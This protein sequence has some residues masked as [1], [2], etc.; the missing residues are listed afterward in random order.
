M[1]RWAHNVAWEG[2]DGA[3]LAGAQLWIIEIKRIVRA[4]KNRDERAILIAV[5]GLPENGRLQQARKRFRH[6]APL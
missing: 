6:F 3:M 1:M 2:N 5:I 4:G